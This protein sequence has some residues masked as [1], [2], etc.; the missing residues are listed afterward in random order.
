MNKIVLVGNPNTGKTTLFNT[1]TGSCNK[2]SNWHGVTVGV[3]KKEIEIDKQNF[4][5]FD[6]PGVYSLEGYSNEEKIAC[7]FLEKNKDSVVV[8]ICDANNFERNLKLTL[9]LIKGGFDVVLAVNMCREAMIYDYKKLSKELSIEIVEIDARSKAGVE[10]LIKTI[11]NKANKKPQNSVK[12]IKNTFLNAQT[13][14]KWKIN[15]TK[16]PY[17]TTDK[18]D[19]FVLNKWLFLIIFFTTVFLI[20]YITF[21]EIGSWFSNELSNLFN[22]LADVLRKIINCTNITFMLKSLICDGVIDAIVSVV[23]FLPQLV[24]LTLFFGCLEETGFMSRVAF[25]LD[26]FLKKFGLTGKSVFSLFMG[27]GCTT[28]AVLTTRNLENLN[29]RKRTALLLPFTQC[30]AKLPV[31]LVIVSLFFEKYRYLFVF[32]FYL[33]S[34]L[35]MLVFA[36]VYQKVLPSTKD[37]FVLEMPKYRLPNFKKL[38][39][40]AWLEIKDFLLKVGTIIVLF[41]CLMWFL[42]NISLDLRFL[43]GK[44]FGES[45][46]HQFSKLIAPVFKFVGIESVGIVCAILFGMVAKEMV[47]V[48]LAAVNGVSGS[49]AA[50]S[51][52]L[53]SSASI[54]HFSPTTSVVF[55]VFILLYSPCVSALVMLK[56]EFGFKFAIFVF[57]AQFLIAYLVSFLV[58]KFLTND[59]FALVVLLL[60]VVAVFAFVVIKLK[61][62]IT[63]RGNCHECKRI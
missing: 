36:V 19:K 16:S 44:D 7:K 39:K 53:L 62:K 8:N 15:N 37:Y 18:I 1:I 45:L 47:V 38:I 50:L 35:L 52:S 5:V 31:F 46:L 24:L 28:S 2:V 34:L 13:I 56:K 14:K 6:L 22:Y 29:L 49:I 3:S 26:G 33:F 51:A 54:C 10:N 42:Q 17:D 25:M 55:L 30:S 58:Y 12:I 4:C 57:V 48:G 60:I 61:K 43:N 21:G 23:S 11:K 27:Y 9:D 32:A 20:F 40:D 63:C 41:S 59:K